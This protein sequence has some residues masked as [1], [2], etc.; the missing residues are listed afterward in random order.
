MLTVVAKGRNGVMRWM[1][2]LRNCT[3]YRGHA[4]FEAE[5]TIRVGDEML[6][7]ERIFINTG[8]RALVPDVPGLANVRYFTN[9]TIMDVDFVPEH[10][11]VGG[12]SYIGLEFAQAYRRFSSRTTVVEMGERLIGR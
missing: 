11:I 4:R 1:E 9:S 7:A 10:L 5:K 2:R 8:G 6:T 12:G 3:V